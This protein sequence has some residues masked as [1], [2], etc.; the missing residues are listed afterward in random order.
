MNKFLNWQKETMKKIFRTILSSI[1]L[2]AIFSLVGYGIFL[3]VTLALSDDNFWVSFSLN[4]LTEIIGAA[5][6]GLFVFIVAKKL[7][8]TISQTPKLAIPEEMMN[9]LLADYGLD[10]YQKMENE[11]ELDNHEKLDRAVRFEKMYIDMR[12]GFFQNDRIAKIVFP[13]VEKLSLHFLKRVM[14]Q[15]NDNLQELREYD[16]IFTDD[17][18]NFDELFEIYKNQLKSKNDDDHKS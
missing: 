2:I 11:G 17:V 13:F 1:L 15:E 3:L 6:T 7:L 14:R 9:T 16:F 5:L 8:P 18:S 10:E 12:E 4:L